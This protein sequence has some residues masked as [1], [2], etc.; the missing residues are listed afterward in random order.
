MAGSSAP[1]TA[2][3]AGAAAATCNPRPFYFSQ[4]RVDPEDPERVYVLG[5]ALHVSEDG[6]RTFR[7]DR[8]GKVHPDNHALAI[9]P[10]SPERLLLGTDGGVYQ[11]FDRA[12]S[13]EHLNR[14]AS[15]EFYR[16]NLDEAVPYRICGGLQDNLN[17]VGPS[18][19]RTKEGILNTDWINIE[20]GDGFSCVFDP[21]DPEV[22]YTESQ[23]GD[24]H[25]FDLRS[26]AVKK[27]RP[28]PHEGQTGYRF[29][30]NSPL[31]G[32]R[33]EKGAMY[34][35]G[36]RVFKL[37]SRGETWKVISPDLSTQDPK[38]TTAVGSGAENYGVVYTLAESPLQKGLLGR[39][40][41][42]GR[43]GSRATRARTG[44]T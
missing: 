30:W 28:A 9:D 44:P 5:F 4:I 39:A 6:G 31:I 11:S 15:G 21:D 1:T 3:R 35:A 24:L 29:H 10:R 32:S 27:L 12:K 43:S 16:I 23:E 17:W 38:K 14:F 34:L 19:T 42:T 7:E 2:G 18:R 41:T 8:F 40:P 37:T 25:R 22:L 26:G 36:N 13:W 20:G 33:H